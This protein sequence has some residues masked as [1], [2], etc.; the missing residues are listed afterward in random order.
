MLAT[1]QQEN[2]K[3]A[4]PLK[5]AKEQLAEL[6]RQLGSQEKE[7]SALTT[8]QAKLKIAKKQVESLTWEAEVLQQKLDK[9]NGIYHKSNFL[10]Q[11]MGYNV[12]CVM[13]S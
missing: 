9:A 6:Q 13:L 7:K 11:L 5:K 2:K 8:T 4:E 12:V 1:V 3:L 10:S